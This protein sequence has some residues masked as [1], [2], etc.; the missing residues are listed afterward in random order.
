MIEV[1]K[2]ASPKPKL[3]IR[4]AT[5]QEFNTY[6]KTIRNISKDAI[7]SNN[8]EICFERELAYNPSDFL[9]TKCK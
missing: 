5:K 6:K 2:Q 8:K 4:P 1:R 9:F 7:L 3:L